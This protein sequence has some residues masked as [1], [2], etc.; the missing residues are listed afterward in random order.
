MKCEHDFKPFHGAERCEKCGALL[1]PS[2][3]S[4]IMEMCGEIS[5]HDRERLIRETLTRLVFMRSSHL[6]KSGP[7]H[8]AT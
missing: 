2:L 1:L 8:R 6:A 4:E 7:W 5:Q 3:C